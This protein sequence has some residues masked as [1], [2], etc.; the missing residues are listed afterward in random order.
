MSHRTRALD[1]DA[2]TAEVDRFLDDVPVAETTGA[3]LSRLLRAVL[4]AEVLP[5]AER[6]ADLGLDPAPL[7]EVVAD[8]LRLYAVILEDQVPAGEI[9]PQG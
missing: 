8:V 4:D 9:T 3:K 1:L 5:Q 2:L 6:A 7:L